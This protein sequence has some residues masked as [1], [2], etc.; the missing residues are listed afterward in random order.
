[1]LSTK[2]EIIPKK[3][4][5]W[6]VMQKSEDYEIDILWKPKIQNVTEYPNNKHIKLGR[7]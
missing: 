3:Y 2:F 5:K 4:K 7:K 6:W 1:M